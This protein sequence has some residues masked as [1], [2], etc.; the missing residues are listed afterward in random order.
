[1]N[2]K[3]ND[4]KEH[5][6]I[7]G[8]IVLS[9]WLIQSALESPCKCEA[10]ARTQRTENIPEHDRKKMNMTSACSGVCKPHGRFLSFKPHKLS[11]KCP[12]SIIYFDKKLNSLV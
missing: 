5:F 12:I 7:N 11:I 9:S 8:V 10:H 2:R 6:A 4:D 3:R 1:M